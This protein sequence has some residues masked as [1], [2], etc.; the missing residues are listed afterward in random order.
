MFYFRYAIVGLSEQLLLRKVGE[1]VY[2]KEC[3]DVQ[4]HIARL[5][6]RSSQLNEEGRSTSVRIEFE[7][8]Y[9]FP[10]FHLGMSF[11]HNNS[12]KYFKYFMMLPRYFLYYFKYFLQL[13]DLEY[14][15]A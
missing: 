11:V 8:E 14:N 3:G 7:N 10:I 4:N 13:S 2:V 15:K 9:P 5:T 6:H 12:L 1:G